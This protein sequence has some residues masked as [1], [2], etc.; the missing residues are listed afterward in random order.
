MSNPTDD[1][2]D[3][4]NQALD[5][6]GAPSIDEIREGSP[7][8]NA[9]LRQYGPT[10]RALLRA[11]P[12]NF[13]R[14]QRPLDLAKDVTNTDGTLPTD[15][16]APWRYEYLYPQD[17]IKLRFVPQVSSAQPMVPALMTNL[18]PPP[19]QSSMGPAP[20]VIGNDLA[21][22]TDSGSADEMIGVTVIL[23]NVFQAQIVYTAAVLNPTLW[24]S[25]FLGGVVAMLAA[26]FAM[27]L[28]PDKK[29][30]LEMRG[31]QIAIVKD[32]VGQARVS[33][34][35]E[36]W[37]TVDHLPDWIRVRGYGGWPSGF[38]TSNIPG[39]GPFSGWESLSFPDGSAY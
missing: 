15:V 16:P 34:G 19:T 11:A 17:C 27:P 38:W 5:E 23:T 37:M 3:V 13:A 8:A 28:A 33:N 21:V 12:W 29:L 30:A 9:A 14:K 10:V 31:Q 2:V 1:M 18:S 4:C 20:Y 32:V 25:Q 36:D 6:I 26:R 22:A 7:S 35:D 24:D 39:L